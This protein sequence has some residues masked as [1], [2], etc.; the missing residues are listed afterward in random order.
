MDYSSSQY[1][2]LSEFIDG[3]AIV[4]EKQKG[5]LNFI[6]ANGNVL[7]A[8]W[9]HNVVPF[10]NGFGG[11]QKHDLKWNSIDKNGRLVSPIWYDNIFTFQDGLA[12]VQREDKLWNFIDTK[13]S[14]LC[15]NM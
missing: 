3:F 2:I 10:R 11:V 5:L 15:P 14:I 12:C 13:G 7:S 1:K 4:G 8:M 9:F 6:D